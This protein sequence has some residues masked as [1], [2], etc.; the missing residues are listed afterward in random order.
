MTF[1]KWRDACLNNPSSKEKVRSQAAETFL[2]NHVEHLT[3][4]SVVMKTKSSCNDA[5]AQL[6]HELQPAFSGAPYVSRICALYCICG[7]IEGCSGLS[8]EIKNLLGNFFLGH[9]GPLEPE[10]DDDDDSDELV[11]DAAVM[12]LSALVRVQTEESPQDGPIEHSVQLLLDLARKGVERR[13]ASPEMDEMVYDHG[14]DFP[15]SKNDIRGGLSTLP[16]S[17]RSLCFDLVRAAI[18]GL[19]LVSGDYL[20]V[21]SVK[22]DLASFAS[23]AAACLHGESDPRCLMQLLR[24]LNALQRNLLRFFQEAYTISSVQFPIVNIFDAV[25]P[26][27]PIQFTPPPNDVHG[28]TRQGLHES[29]MAVLCFT[30]YDSFAA[31]QDTMLNLTAGIFLERLI[32]LDNDDGTS[33]SSVDDKLDA[34]GDLMTLLFRDASLCDLMSEHT[35]KELSTALLTT[36]A[37][38]ASVATIG[39]ENGQKNKALADACRNLVSKVAS[40]LE[41]SSQSV[42]WDIFVHDT[43]RVWSPL[44][45]SSPQSLKGRSSIA[46]LACLCASGGPR[47]LNLCLQS[48]LPLLIDIL[49][50]EK[51]DE[52]K[53][54]AA[55][56]GIGAFFSSIQ[57]AF[58][59]GMKDGVTLHPHPL[60]TFGADA[61]RALNDLMGINTVTERDSSPK[62]VKEVQPS[63]RIA[64]VSAIDSVLTVMPASLLED[65]D[66]DKVCSLFDT[67]VS[68]VEDTDNV[69]IDESASTDS[70]IA[71]RTASARTIGYILGKSFEDERSDVPARFPCLLDESEKVRRH[72]REVILPSLLLSSKGL[73]PSSNEEN[74]L[75]FDWMALACCCETNQNAANKVL[76]ALVNSLNDALKQKN[77]ANQQL[78]VHLAMCLCFVIQH[79]GAQA[80]TAFRSLSAPNASPMDLIASV[81]SMSAA[82][83]EKAKFSAFP[84]KTRVSRVSTLM[85]PPT[86]EDREEVNSMVRFGIAFRSVL[87][88]VLSN[89]SPTLCTRT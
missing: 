40:A 33:P 28:I 20:R 36:H 67:L 51:D 88:S 5:L 56:Y 45:S 30:G 57:V 68:L 23:F 34:I 42:L 8:H 39:G 72:L 21:S 84:E 1:G 16:R 76:S 86:S 46:Y 87:Y 52:E 83:E 18:D 64:A 69:T 7:A 43:V 41:V 62:N 60:E 55:A 26:Y 48:C 54:A 89:S 2:A 35:V 17:R 85:L 9:C 29:L 32:P 11:R 15:S 19:T 81:C 75:R 47:T 73:L 38:A 6:I 50:N 71:L 58:S 79:G 3:P 14:Y 24:M 66:F 78:E 61:F 10:D 4:E 49:N 25:A 70:K 74:P 53:V 77:I 13:C 59:L 80:I 44:L 12:C 65:G 37:E 63:L 31:G 22:R 27:Y 82:F